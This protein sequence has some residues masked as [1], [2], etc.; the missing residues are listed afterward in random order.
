MAPFLLKIKIIFA[1]QNVLITST[2]TEETTPGREVLVRALCRAVAGAMANGGREHLSANQPL[3]AGA[4]R[5]EQSGEKRPWT[6]KCAGPP[7]P[8]PRPC[9]PLLAPGRSACARKEA[10]RLA[11]PLS[12]TNILAPNLS[13]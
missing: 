11:S 5:V 12:T 13:L 9:P 2:P 4:R 3:A 7:P 6:A 8:P 1:D 10:P